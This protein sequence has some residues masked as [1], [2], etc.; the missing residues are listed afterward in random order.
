MAKFGIIGPGYL[1]RSSNVNASRC[2]NFYPELN[3]QDSKSVGSL[4]GTPGSLLFVDSASGVIRGMHFFNNLIYFVA[5]DK[6]Y[7]VNSAQIVSAVIDVGTGLQVVLATATGRVVMADNGIYSV[8]GAVANQLAFS[9]GQTVYVYNITT[10]VLFSLPAPAK[11]IAFI[12]GYFM[13]NNTGAQFRISDLYNGSSWPALAISTA[14]AYPDNLASV[15][16]NHNEAWLIGEYSTEVWTP[17]GTANPMPFSRM[18]IIDYGTKAPYSVAKGSNSVFFLVSQRNGAAGEL[19]GIGMANGYGVDIV[20]PVAIN[21]QISNY[22]VVED[23]WGYCYSER[24]HEFYVLTFPTANA[25]WVYD[26]TTGLFHE[27]SYYSGSP[28]IINRHIANAY[29]HAWGKHYIGSYVDGKIYEMSE[30][31]YDDNGTTI[32]SV[33]VAPPLDENNNNVFIS[34]LQLDAET[35]V[36]EV[37][38][39]VLPVVEDDDDICGPVVIQRVAY[40]YGFVWGGTY[41]DPGT[42]YKI[43]PATNA[44]LATKNLGAVGSIV[45]DIICVLGD[46]WVLCLGNSTL[47]QIN[48]GTL[49]VTSTTWLPVGVC[50]SMIEIGGHLW[51]VGGSS[52]IEFDPTTLTVLNTVAVGTAAYDLAYDGTDI[53]VTRFFPAVNHVVRVDPVTLTVKSYI[54]LD[55]LANPVGIEFYAGFIWVVA[56]ATGN[57][58][59]IDPASESVLTIVLSDDPM[60]NTYGI[61]SGEGYLWISDYDLGLLHKVRASTG[62]LVATLDCGIANLQGITYGASH[63]WMCTGTGH[64][65]RTSLGTVLVNPDVDPQ[66]ILSWSTDG[67]HTW[68]NDHP[69]SM[70]KAGQYTKRIIWR[71]LGAARNRSFRVAITAAV[72]RVLIGC[73]MDHERGA[74]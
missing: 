43:D 50:S 62:E 45:D 60:S 24:G 51:I 41:A 33:R 28:Y 46:I 15:V 22:A 57:V 6:L 34:K 19:F 49:V 47:L 17:D 52:L 18:A 1:G 73:Y 32:A 40:G 27:R 36:G 14:D 72:K 56:L 5:A 2:I 39:P 59:R 54:S 65:L 38:A 66:V 4:V 11:S 35:G 61:V 48:P 74:D 63:I 3:P 30:D 12:G 16:N 26:V 70:G 29:A 67:G 37:D 25:T 23:A 31:Y 8:G 13:I 64:V 10:G 9:D 7:S 44:V 71:R 55:A 20:S 68:S 21:Y 53:W 69:A 42:L 58:Y